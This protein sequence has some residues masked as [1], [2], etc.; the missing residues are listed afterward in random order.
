MAGHIRAAKAPPLPDATAAPDH[1]SRF[2]R[3]SAIVAGAI[4][5]LALIGMAAGIGMLTRWAPS[6]T[7]M[8]PLTAVAII[9]ASAGILLD[10]RTQKRWLQFLAVL[11][12]AIGASKI[13][14]IVIGHPLGIDHLA[15]NLLRNLG[16]QAPDPVAPNTAVVLVLLGS[17]MV[18]AREQKPARA[19]ISQA[20]ALAG[21]AIAIMALVGFVLGATTL[22]Q[23]IFNRMAVNTAVA[24]TAL[25]AA[26]LGL[27]GEH[28]VMRLLNDDG[29]AG[30]MARVAIPICLILPVALGVSRLRVDGTYIGTLGDGVALMIIGNIILSLALLWTCLTLLLRADRALRDKTLA[31]SQSE[32]RYRVAQRIARTGHWEYEARGRTLG[33]SSEFRTIL[34][35]PADREAS[36]RA[37]LRLIHPDDRA[38]VQAAIRSGLTSG[39]GWMVPLRV[40]RAD[41][42]VQYLQSHGVC[43]LDPAGR[44]VSVFGVV[45]DVTELELARRAA[46]DSTRA[47]AAFL[48]NIS[49]EIRTPLNGVLGFIQLLMDSK[50][51]ATQRRYLTLVEESAQILLKLLNDILDLSKIQAGH[52]EISP[53]PA[54]LRRVIRHSTRLMLPTAEQKGLLLRTSVDRISPTAITINS[55]RVRQIL[56]NILGNALKFTAHGTVSVSLRSGLGPNN[57][58]ELYLDVADEGIGIARGTEEALFMPFVQADNSTSRRFGGSGLGLSIS[59]HLAERMGG[60][61]RLEA[62]PGG[63]AVAKLTLPLELAQAPLAR[64]HLSDAASGGTGAQI[65][66]V[67]DDARGREGLSILLVEDLEI[68]RELVGAML[69]RLGHKVEFATD[70]LDAVA[71]AGRLLGEPKAWDLILMDVQ[72]PQM[73]GTQATMRIRELGGA[74]ATIP[75]VALSANAFETE[76]QESRNAGMNDHMVKPVGF[77][78]LHDTIE[79]WGRP[80][81][82]RIAAAG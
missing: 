77:E 45:N 19:A 81:R 39:E 76:I 65:T 70:G 17:A 42:S 52:L 43:T 32:D 68:N 72:M 67:I 28:G 64:T 78:Q 82:G 18:L 46:E 73:N 44:L 36:V 66:R 79:R 26:V 5:A 48:A 1:F 14:Q 71:K 6:S 15:S 61:L 37:M 49:H 10:E 9:V 27:T 62:R 34:G 31:V 13:L 54:D 51:N 11:V 50:L 20:L 23:L 56:V 4:S 3:V 38:T 47:Q 12:I 60:T 24:L 21:I 35:L 30:L 80:Q 8:S 59:R 33:W 69:D 40:R 55:Y 16:A 2:M 29:R 63:G 7:T 25:G 58:R 22:N 74:A 57:R 41:G 75:I 53:H